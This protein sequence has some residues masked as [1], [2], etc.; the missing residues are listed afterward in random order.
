MHEQSDTSLA[1]YSSF[2]TGGQADYLF[3]VNNHNEFLD[4]INELKNPVWI[5]GQGTNSLISDQGLPG[6]VILMQSNNL[7]L[8]DATL[9][10]DAGVSWDSLVQRAVSENL[11]GMELMS[12]I[13]GSVGAAVVG[14]IAAYGQSVADSLNWVEV[15]DRQQKKIVTLQ[16]EEL[17]FNYRYSKLLDEKN[18]HMVVLRAG[19]ELSTEPVQQ[20]EYRSALSVA[21]ELQIDSDSLAG[22]RKIILEAR[23]RAGALKDTSVKTAGSFFKNPVVT[24]EQAE[25]ILGFEEN[26]NVN[27]AQVMQ[28]NKIHGGSA[29]RVSAAHVLLAAGFKRGQSWGPVRLHPDHVLKIENHGGATSQQIYD[30]AQEIIA[31]VKQKLDVDLEPEVRFLGEFN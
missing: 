15:Y 21:Q 28:Q 14:N 27:V 3:L 30:V 8:Q 11:W 18:A 24:P 16:K 7:E 23:K 13:P 1:Q 10:A 19:F 2:G 9:I 31:T 26:A 4:S 29:H 20:L 12:G 5:L 6:T 25:H 17:G 22:R